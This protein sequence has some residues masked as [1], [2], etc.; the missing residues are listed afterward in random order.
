MVLGLL[1]FAAVNIVFELNDRFADSQYADYAT[2]LTV[3]NW[4]VVCLKL[5]G[6]AVALLSIWR[7]RVLPVA[8][9]T[10]LIWGCF[11][12]FVVYGASSLV[13]MLAIALGVTGD[14][15][16]IDLAG[17]GYVLG[18]LLLASGFGLL[19]ISFSRRHSIRK[20]FAVLGVLGAPVLLVL[21]LMAVPALLAAFDIM[22]PP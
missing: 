14:V 12:T 3:M 1:G 2:G 18:F 21:V 9:L 10:V 11:A 8:A 15:G 20:R 19:T 13:Q 6:A 22:P 16:D 4:L 7:P 5:L 17:F